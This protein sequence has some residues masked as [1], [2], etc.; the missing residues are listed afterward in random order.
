MPLLSK[1]QVLR[2]SSH[3]LHSV[4]CDQ[5]CLFDKEF[6]AITEPGV[7]ANALLKNKSRILLDVFY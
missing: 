3:L 4:F 7:P 1:G 2:F 5:E 6:Q